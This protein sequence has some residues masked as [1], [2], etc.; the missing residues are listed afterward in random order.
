MSD[1]VSLLE[2]LG[3]VG[4]ALR[5]HSSSGISSTARS[6]QKD[7]AFCLF[8]GLS[9]L[10]FFHRTSSESLSLKKLRSQ[11]ALQGNPLPR[12]ASKN[13]KATSSCQKKIDSQQ[14]WKELQWLLGVAAPTAT[15]KGG[16]LMA[17]QFVLLVMRTMI[18]VRCTKLNTYFLTRAISKAS[19]SDWTKWVYSFTGWM[20]ASTVVNSGLRYMESVIALELRQKLTE[21]AHRKY[22]LNNAFYRLAVLRHGN[23]GTVDQRIVSDIDAF[24]REAASLYGHSFKPI[25]EFFLSLHEASKELGMGRPIA[26]FA[27]QFFIGATLRGLTPSLGKM[28]ALEQELEGNFRSGHSRLIASAEEVAFLKG[29]EAERALLD[30]SLHR[31]IG[32]QRWHALK[33][34]RKSIVDNITKFQGLLIGGCFVH[35]PFLARKSAEA[36][37]RISDFRATEELMLRCGSAFSEIMLLGKSLDELAGYTSRIVEMFRALETP[38]PARDAASL[39]LATRTANEAKTKDAIVITNLTVHQPSPDGTEPRVLITGLNL[40]VPKGRHVIV[41]GPNG[42]GKTSLFRVLAGLWLP[43]EGAV[44]VPAGK[45]MLWLPQSSYLVTGTLR[46]QVTYPDRP[47]SSRSTDEKI[48]DCLEKVGLKKLCKPSSDDALG[49]GVRHHDWN[50]VLSGGEKQRV[51]FARLLYHKPE[52]AILDEATAAINPEEESKL[53][54][55]VLG[56]G[57][58]V[59]SIAHRLELRK[60]HTTELHVVGDGSGTFKLSELRNTLDWM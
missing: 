43:V 36:A 23:L 50:D 21:R 18:T 47:T 2:G 11:L 16:Q 8:L 29:S 58:T 26:L 3:L 54:E 42:C 6:L 17:A 38:P 45:R 20:A 22:L 41:T 49:L 30:E 60:F 14:F 31:L 53:Y 1:A 32:T 51:S 44:A 28:V 40:T 56:V 27:S 46:D 34:I 13:H 7:S 10:G 4:T 37:E 19:W 52:Y 25:L 59:F 24:S 15:S 9:T 48:A 57:T 55:M 33:R 5:R 12:A 35:V 39:A